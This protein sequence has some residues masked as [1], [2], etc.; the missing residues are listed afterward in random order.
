M[1]SAGACGDE[2]GGAGAAGGAATGSGG[3][4]GQG[5]AGGS[6][7]QGGAGETIPE[8]H[9][10]SLAFGSEENDFPTSIAVDGD[11]N[12]LFGGHSVGPIDFGAGALP[13]AGALDVL[14][15]KWSPEGNLVWASRFGG[16]EAQVLFGIAAD[17]AGNVVVAGS[18]RGS[19]D[20]GGGPLASAGAG[21]IYVAKLDPSG[22]HLWSKAFT[23]GDEETAHRLALDADDNILLGGQFEGTITF[24][25][26]SL[27]SAGGSDI[28]VVKL[29][30]TGKYAWNKSFGSASGDSYI[31]T[32]AAASDGGAVI[33][34]SF[35]DT[36]DF[37]G[38]PLTGA[39]ADDVFVARIDGFGDPVWSKSYGS[40]GNQSGTAVHVDAAGSVILA[41]QFVGS[42]DFGGG[43]LTAAEGDVTRP[44]IFV[45]KLDAAGSHTWSKRFGDVDIDTAA[46]IRADSDG[47]IVLAGGFK[48]AIDFGGGPLASAGGAD[49]YSDVFVAKFDPSGAQLWARRYGDK[50]AQEA[51]AVAIDSGRNIVLTG[52]FVGTINFG[53][54][55]LS[56]PAFNGRMF[57]AKLEP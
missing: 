37:G 36:I 9:I 51:A 43:A 15:A 29:D 10:W 30:P 34:G 24:G 27:T 41:G 52:D 55:P 49:G 39:G 32:L 3:S 53:G 14:V 21:D 31:N 33:A 18:F 20:F 11:D 45:A 6:G 4:G 56:V 13:P 22:K 7:G 48:G 5:G 17:S 25:G 40:A 1:V 8:G 38:G 12:V 23:G 46:G 19:I 50:E 54:N 57:V 42:I 2:T 26:G 35:T 28:F 16:A 47:N 44:D